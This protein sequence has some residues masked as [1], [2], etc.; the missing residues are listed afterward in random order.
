MCAQDALA[1]FGWSFL[2]LHHVANLSLLV[3]LMW[4][5]P[6]L[7]RLAPLALLLPA[8]HFALRLLP[9]LP[10]SIHF[11]LGLYVDLLSHTPLARE[12]QGEGAGSD[13]KQM[14]PAQVVGEWA[15]TC[16]CMALTIAFSV[17]IYVLMCQGVAESLVFCCYPVRSPV[18]LACR[19]PVCPLGAA[20]HCG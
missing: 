17:S 3:L 4:G 19:H 1:S 11:K 5:W 8:S 9:A 12:L 18:R 6:A 2:S 13:N 14:A 16:W 15:A 10:P 7:A 20:G